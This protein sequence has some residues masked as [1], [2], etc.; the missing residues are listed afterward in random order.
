MSCERCHAEVGVIRR[1]QKKVACTTLINVV[2]IVMTVGI[3]ISPKC[4]SNMLKIH[5]SIQKFLSV[6]TRTFS[7][8]GL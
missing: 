1:A 2:C 7:W 4:D 3:S 8:T 6:Y 5:A